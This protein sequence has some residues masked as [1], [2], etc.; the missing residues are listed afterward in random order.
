MWLYP[1]PAVIA[2][3]G[4]AAIFVSTGTQLMLGALL[5]TLVGV[6]VYLVRARTLKQWPFQEAAA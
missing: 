1:V 6:I 2:I 3:L 5:F 4:W